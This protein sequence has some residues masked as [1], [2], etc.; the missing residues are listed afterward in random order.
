MATSQM[1]FSRSKAVGGPQ[2][3]A[4]GE[5]KEGKGGVQGPFGGAKLTLCIAGVLEELDMVKV[6]SFV[7]CRLFCLPSPAA[8]SGLLIQEG[9]ILRLSGPPGLVPGKC[10][11]QSR[12][13]RVRSGTQP[14]QACKVPTM[15]SLV[16]CTRFLLGKACGRI[17]WHCSSFSSCPK[18]GS[19]RGLGGPGPEPTGTCFSLLLDCGAGSW[20]LPGLGEDLMGSAGVTGSRDPLLSSRATSRDFTSWLKRPRCSRL[21]RPWVMTTSLWALG[22]T[23]GSRLAKGGS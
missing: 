14:W 23:G 6:S 2:A 8:C 21:S 4:D 9:V 22:A 5:G 11:W 1:L 15:A 13:T 16:S 20:A 18:P 10:G 7:P 19:S 3:A 17:S 12:S